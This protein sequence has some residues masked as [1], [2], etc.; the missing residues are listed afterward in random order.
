MLSRE[1]FR[2]VGWQRDRRRKVPTKSAKWFKSWFKSSFKG[3]KWKKKSDNKKKNKTCLYFCLSCLWQLFVVVVFSIYFNILLFCSQNIY[4]EIIR[5]NKGITIVRKNIRFRIRIF[6]RKEKKDSMNKQ[7]K[8]MATKKEN[9]NGMKMEQ[10]SRRK[11]K[12]NSFIFC[13]VNKMNR[14]HL[15]IG[16][17]Q[18]FIPFIQSVLF[19]V[20]VF[21]QEKKN[22]VKFNSW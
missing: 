11:K 14:K 18:S 16:Y 3:K 12:N 5:S 21:R 7:G 8:K 10:N 4:C 13:Q 15:S 6:S 20:V 9:R 17:F 22:Y 2:V 1:W 19:F